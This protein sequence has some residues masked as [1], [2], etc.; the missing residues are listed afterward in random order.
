MQGVVPLTQQEITTRSRESNLG[1][2]R[3][4]QLVQTPNL[5]TPAPSV[6]GTLPIV[7]PPPNHAAGPPVVVGYSDACPPGLFVLKDKICPYH[8]EG[9]RYRTHLQNLLTRHVVRMHNPDYRQN[10]RRPQRPRT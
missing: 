8:N 6:N 1:T 7:T 3:T 2:P 5:R 4:P 9:C 10:Y